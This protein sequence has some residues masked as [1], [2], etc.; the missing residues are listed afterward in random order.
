MAINFKHNQTG[1]IKEC[2]EGFSWTC[3]CFGPFVPAIR[4]M[5][6][7]FVVSLF[8]F[9]LATWYYMFAINKLYAVHLM[10]KGYIPSSEIDRQKVVSLG[11][12]SQSHPAVSAA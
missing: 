12:L 9:N 7:P 3:F 6:T 2:P 10:E 5:W 4:G 8:T 1:V 11:I